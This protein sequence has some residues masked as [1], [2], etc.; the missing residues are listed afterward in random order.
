MVTIHRKVMFI[1][2][3]RG[4]KFFPGMNQIDDPEMKRIEGTK[5]FKEEIA[6][7][8]MVVGGHIETSNTDAVEATDSLKVRAHKMAQGIKEMKPA[9]AKKLIAE[10]GDGYFLRAIKEHDPRKGIQ[11]AVDTRM[12]EIDGQKGSDLTPE[13]K[14]APEGNGTDFDAKITGSKED[15]SGIKGHSAIPALNKRRGRRK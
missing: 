7:G 13:S 9:E 8:N 4:V 1:T 14:C 15:V 11:D 3:I 10:M 2:I 5:A 12:N 6:C